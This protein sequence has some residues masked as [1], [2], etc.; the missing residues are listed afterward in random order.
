[1][2]R[3]HRPMNYQYL[4]FVF[5]LFLSVELLFARGPPTLWANV[6]SNFLTLDI[7]ENQSIELN[8]PVNSSPDLSI[9]WAKNNEDLDPMWSPANLLIRK[10]VLKIEHVQS[11]DAGLYKC[12]V[13]NGFGSVQAQFR[14]N[15]KVNGSVVNAAN[16]GDPSQGMD[17]DIDALNGEAPEFLIRND[18]NPTGPTTVIQPEGT[19]VQLKC[20]ASGKPMPDIRWKKNG[21]I[22]SEDEY[23][24]TQSQIL[25]IKDLRQTDTGNYTCE[26]FNSFGAINATFVLMVTEKLTF[27]GPDPQNTSVEIGQRAALHCRV[28]S[29]DKTLKIQWLK[30]IDSQ[31]T[32]RADAIVFDSDQYEPIEQLHHVDDDH[33]KNFISKS[34]IFDHV[35]L[36]HQG[37]Y[38]CLIQNEKI[39]NYKKAFLRVINTRQGLMSSVNTNEFN[40]LYVILVPLAFLGFVLSLIYCF[41]RRRRNRKTSKHH[42]HHHSSAHSHCSD[43]MKSSVKA[44]PSYV[45]SNGVV[46]PSSATTRTSNDYIATSV[47][48]IPI[49]RHYQQVQRYGLPLSSDLASLTSSNLYY[50]RVQAI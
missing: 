20:L 32:F 37:Q 7:E 5:I 6:S 3:F 10:L 13:V 12:N 31:Q 14:L 15:V 19:T 48:S 41:R 26:L 46:L 22:L 24:V 34:L 43:S 8:C 25:I 35:A 2:I 45:H 30:R 9:Q 18:E 21:K 11:S 16:G 17:W 23:G 47:D 39:T 38:I 50:A 33:P 49:P 36:S 44:R 1:M 27:F 29:Q 40:L 4:L 28:Q 42:Q